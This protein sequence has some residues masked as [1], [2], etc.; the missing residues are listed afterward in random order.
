MD[1]CRTITYAF[2]GYAMYECGYTK[3]ALDNIGNF[4]FLMLKD[5]F[6]KWA[7]DKLIDYDKC[8]EREE[9]GNNQ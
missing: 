2:V 3:E 1:K 5:E 9:K 8:N 6:E 4:E 7:K